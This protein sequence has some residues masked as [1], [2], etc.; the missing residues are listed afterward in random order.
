MLQ[1]QCTVDDHRQNV[2]LLATQPLT[3][4]ENWRCLVPNTIT[5]FQRGEMIAQKATS[6]AATRERG[7][8]T[9]RGR[10]LPDPKSRGGRKRRAHRS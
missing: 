7:R 2:V 8:H 10:S 9:K 3:D 6:G 4:D 1:R 5:A